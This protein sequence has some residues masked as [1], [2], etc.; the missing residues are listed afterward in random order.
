M[1]RRIGLLLL[2]LAA[3][4]AAVAAAAFLFVERHEFGPLAER[5]AGKALGRPVSVAGL[6][7][8]PGRWIAV[9]LSGA[10]L[11][12]APGGSRPAMAEVRRLTAEVDALSLLRG[13]VV[14]RRLAVEGLSVLLERAAGDTPNWRFGPAEPRPDGPVDRSWFPTLLDARLRGSEVAFRTSSGAVLRVRLDDVSLLAA[15]DAEPVRLAAEGAYNGVPVGLDAEL[16]PF[17]AF[18]NAAEPFGTLLHFSSGGA[19]LEFRGTMEA[20]LEVDGARGALSL[21]APTLRPLLAIAGVRGEVDVPLRLAGALERTGDLWRLR[22]LSGALGPAEVTAGSLRLAEGGRGE[23]DSVAVDLAFDRLD[24]NEV[25][26]SGVRGRR[27]D[28]DLPLRVDRAPGA[29]VDARLAAR[30]LLYGGVQ[31]GDVAFEGTLRPGRIA[32]DSL[33]LTHLGAAIRA[34]GAV[35]AVG[36]DRGHAAVQVAVSGLDIQR[37]RR[38]LGFGPIPIHGAMDASVAAS[39]GGETLN[40]AARAA[41]VSAVASMDGGRVGRE[42]IETT[43]IDLR[44]LFRKAEGGS[45]VSCLLGVLDMQAGVGTVAPLRLR[46]ADGTITGHARFDLNRRRFDLT[47]GSDPDT[48]NFFALDIPV[49]VYGTFADPS[50]W[51]ARWSP[52]GRAMLAAGEDVRR[53]PAHL[54][55]AARGNRCYRGR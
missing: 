48:T 29:L 9:N 14:V 23:P 28:A 2:A 40:A 21:A 27:V 47:I 51:P 53:L 38:E 50:V 39:G 10:R 44:R 18:R 5:R 42:V 45:A 37:L 24:L 11:D 26:G 22:G 16:Q 4:L 41:R 52:A 35:E 31:A 13:P 6:R 19:T 15:G 25:L 3:V 20:P 36:E 55:E 7:V 33:A 30:E 46:A 49:R 8:S 17:A 12:N 34:S 43:S 32:V 54:A 1:W